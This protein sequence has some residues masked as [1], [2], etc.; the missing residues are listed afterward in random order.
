MDGKRYEATVPDT[1]D[2][3][4]RA[5]LASADV[6]SIEFPMVETTETYTLPRD[7]PSPEIHHRIYV[8]VY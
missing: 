5:G 8:R 7:L 6:I 1:L 2:L 4:Y 3:A